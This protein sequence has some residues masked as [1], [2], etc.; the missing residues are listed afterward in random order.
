MRKYIKLSISAEGLNPKSLLA[1]HVLEIYDYRGARVDYIYA[2]SA[3]RVMGAAWRVFVILTCLR[4]RSVH[5]QFATGGDIIQQTLINGNFYYVHSF[6]SIGTFAFTPSKPLVCD[7]L[8][9]GGGG[10]GGGGSGNWANGGGGGG[11]V[12]YITQQ[13]I[14]AAQ[15]VTVAGGGGNSSFGAFTAFAGG[16]GGSAAGS[17]K[18]GGWPGSNDAEYRSRFVASTDGHLP[19]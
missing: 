7:I 5:A 11:G 3:G 1:K 13:P 12:L 19:T 17:G 8:V 15:S 6:K 16:S 10:A 14:S 9:V 18:N 2:R 4:V